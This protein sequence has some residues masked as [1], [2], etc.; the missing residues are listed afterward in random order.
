MSQLQAPR[1]ARPLR[2]VQD[3]EVNAP[4]HPTPLPALSL[5]PLRAALVPGWVPGL[6]VQWEWEGAPALGRP[7]SGGSEGHDLEAAPSK[8]EEGGLG[9]LPEGGAI[10]HSPPG[11]WAPDVSFWHRPDLAEPHSW[12]LGRGRWQTRACSGPFAYHLHLSAYAV[13]LPGLLCI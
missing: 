10:E 6:G 11:L 8:R 2:S 7:W 3:L 12:L 1:K 9:K 13:A 4:A 5:Q